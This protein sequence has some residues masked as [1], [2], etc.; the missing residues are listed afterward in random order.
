MSTIP[1]TGSVGPQASEGLAV[2]GSTEDELEPIG[3]LGLGGGGS[4]DEELDENCELEELEEG[5]ELEEDIDEGTWIGRGITG[6]SVIAVVGIVLEEE[7][8]VVKLIE[9]EKELCPVVDD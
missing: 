8:D 6:L 7:P 5:C 4:D 1:G 2:G 9:L 3:V